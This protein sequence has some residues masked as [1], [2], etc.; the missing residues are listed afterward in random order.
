MSDIELG[1][2]A[3][4]SDAAAWVEAAD[5][6][7]EAG[8]VV[9]PLA[10]T[11]ADVMSFAAARGFH[12]HYGVVLAKLED[13]VRQG[14]LNF[15]RIADSLVRGVVMY[16]ASEEEHQQRLRQAGGR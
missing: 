2:E 10:L 5:G 9:A 13:S 3:L 16:Q 6:L 15:H 7:A 14:T 4:K 11:P 8:A 1:L 12:Y